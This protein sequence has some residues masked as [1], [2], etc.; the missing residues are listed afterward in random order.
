MYIE[1]QDFLP[2]IAGLSRQVVYHGSGL[3]NS[4]LSLVV[5]QERFHCT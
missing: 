2:G 5:S 4:I 3:R 1:K